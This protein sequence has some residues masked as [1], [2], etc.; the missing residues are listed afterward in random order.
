MSDDDEFLEDFVEQ[1][2]SSREN[3][4]AGKYEDALAFYDGCAL[5]CLRRVCARTASRAPAARRVCAP[6]TCRRGVWGPAVV[7]SWQRAGADAAED[8]ARP[9]WRAHAQVDG[10]SRV[11]H[12][13][14]PAREGDCAGERPSDRSMS[15]AAR[16][17]WR[18]RGGV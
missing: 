12:M 6:L 2:K 14:G 9:R 11:H 1:I 3:A 16:Q 17:P 8:E 7:R 13:R 4:M 18:G 15:H 5:A 10:G